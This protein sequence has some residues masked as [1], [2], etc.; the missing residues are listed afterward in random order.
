MASLSPT[1]ANIISSL[2]V[3]GAAASG[4][5]PPSSLAGFLPILGPSG[6][7]DASFVPADAA[8]VSLPTLAD[9]AYIDPQTST[10]DDVRRGSIVAPYRSLGE[11]AASFTPSLQ[12][13]MDGFVAFVLAPGAYT[14]AADATVAFKSSFHPK[15]VVIA[16]AGQCKFISTVAVTG[17]ASGATVYLRDMTLPGFSAA[18]ARV[19]CL[20][21]TV[22]SGAVTAA[23]LSLSADSSVGG[24]RPGSV[25][26]LADSD[27][28]GDRSSL[29][30]GTVSG[31]I[32]ALAKRAIRRARLTGCHST[33]SA[34]VSNPVDVAADKNGVYDM[35]DRDSMLV[36]AIRDLYS[37]VGQ[38]SM[39][40][41]TLTAGKVVTTTLS[42]K[43]LELNGRTVRIDAFGYLVVEGT[44]ASSGSADAS[45]SVVLR[46]QAEGDGRMWLVGV[47]SGRLFVEEYAAPEDDD[48]DGETVEAVDDIDLDDLGTSY[49][50][51]MNGGRLVVTRVS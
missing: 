46:D 34:D 15:T 40:V 38:G 3:K 1:A 48:G 28:V 14:S 7:L 4:A 18:G 32:D 35:S 2:G 20:G 43:A 26:L 12:A 6:K 10:G 30:A 9:A 37:K 45:G 8:Q 5:S 13:Q 23:S 33:L 11:A 25:A 22:V 51:T 47:S 24:D 44:S 31:A 29:E 49:K 21:R 36:S 39:T 17:L 16:C 41:E 42:I 50:V 27:R 19:V